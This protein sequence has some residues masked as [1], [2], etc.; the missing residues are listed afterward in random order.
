M[1]TEEEII[2]EIESLNEILEESEGEDKAFFEG[3]IA[4]YRMLL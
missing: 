2:K 3:E 1:E 4:A